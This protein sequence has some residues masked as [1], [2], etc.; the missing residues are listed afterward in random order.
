MKALHS[1]VGDKG[2]EIGTGHGQC[3]WQ[4]IQSMCLQLLTLVGW[5]VTWKGD[6]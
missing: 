3:G 2:L 5:G 4:G 1:I 6:R